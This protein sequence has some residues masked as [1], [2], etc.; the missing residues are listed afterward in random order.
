MPAIISPAESL[1]L[2]GAALDSRLRNAG[3]HVADATL[4]RIAERLRADAFANEIIYQ[5]DNGEREAVR[6]MLRP[7]LAHRDQLT[8][9]HHVCLQIT[10][11]LRRL[12][13]L[14]LVDPEIRKIVKLGPEEERWLRENWT[15]DHSRTNAIYGRL[16]AVCDFTSAG[17]QDTLKFMEPNLSG[18][19]GINYAPVAEQIVMR[20]VVPTLLAHDPGLILE[21][22]QDQRDLFV[23]VLIDHA[24]AM[25]RDSCRLCFVE[26]RFE[27]G[28]PDEQSA[29]SRYLSARHGLTIAHADPRELTVKDGEAYFGDICIDVVYRDY[30]MRDLIALE[31]ELGRPMEAMRLLFRENRVVSSLVGDLDH[32]SGFEI[33]TD[34]RLAERLFS[35]DDC[36]LFNRHVLW[37]RLV[38]DRKTTLPGNVEGDLLDYVRSHREQLV[39]KPNRGYGGDGVAIGAAK[40]QPEWDEILDEA[41]SKG[42]DPDASWVVQSATQIPVAEFPVVGNDGRVYSEPFYAVMGFAPT[43]GG[44]GVLCRVSQK[45][46]VNVAQHGGLAA[47]LVAETPTDLRIPKRPLKAVENTLEALR[48][49]IVE[50]RHLD[51]TVALLEWD[52]ETKLPYGGRLQRGE[53]IGTLE[54]LRHHLLASDSLGDLIEEAALQSDDAGLSRELQLLRRE[55]KRALAVPEDIVR[56]LANAKSQALAGWEDARAKNEFATFAVPF[57]QLLALVRERAQALAPQGDPYDALLDEYEPG[58]T[59]SRLLPVLSEMRERLVPLVKR[60]AERAPDNASSRQRFAEAGQ[61]ELFRRVLRAI[62]FDFERGRLDASTHPFTMQTSD[63]DVRLTSRVDEADLASGLLATM[64]EGGHAL[65]DQGFAAR[66][67]DTLL[68]EGA[69]SGLHEGQARLWENHV[70]RS[71][72]FVEFLMPH[73]RELFP[74]QFNSPD[75]GAI[76]K[77]VNAVRPGLIRVGADEMSYHLHIVLRTELETA[78]LSGA[79]A[80]G[81]LPQTWNARS[82]SLIGA[83]PKTDRDGVLQDVHWAVGMFGYFPTYTIGSLYAAQLVETYSATRDLEGEIRAGDFASLR[84][85]LK[86]NVYD[87]G[88]RLAAENIVTRATGRGLDTAAYFAHVTSPK[89]AWN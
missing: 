3:R 67:R 62:G 24:R 54:G 75:A 83:T 4:A 63:D 19:G 38:A 53:Q 82:A 72:A 85:W 21:L 46:V 78:L 77:S 17:W 33:L 79:L 39:L 74:G 80:I 44:L 26:P 60:A 30:E 14:Y 43:D 40:T 11:A 35:P 59:Q 47:L 16:D 8:Y 20:D 5:R 50:L 81:D 89:R 51:Q 87:F 32:K 73:L 9:V 27:E 22:P 42:D 34:R 36:R 23:Q 57:S 45:Q 65:Y 70:G 49:A 64:H 69:S 1:G 56:A 41:A 29:L 61:W 6:V 88:N 31:K 37:T 7:L 12:P 66:D 25:G 58:M 10:E 15:P 55:R 68:A 84:A 71:R 86:A 76:W 52:E 18:V 48:C 28:G 2:A 13:A